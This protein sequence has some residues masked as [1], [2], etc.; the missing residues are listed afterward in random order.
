MKKQISRR[1]IIKNILFGA[2]AL[3]LMASPISSF[4]KNE[5]ETYEIPAKPI[6]N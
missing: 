1:E 6:G 5:V 3:P 4:G 2:G